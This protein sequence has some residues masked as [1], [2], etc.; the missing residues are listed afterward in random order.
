MNRSW[1]KIM[2]RS[3]PCA[4]PGSGCAGPGAGVCDTWHAGLDGLIDV[5]EGGQALDK[6][7]LVFLVFPHDLCLGVREE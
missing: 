5:C 6:L 4:G 2:N 3:W 1:R 7:H